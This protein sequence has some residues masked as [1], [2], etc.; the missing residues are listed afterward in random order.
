[1][2][3]FQQLIRQNRVRKGNKKNSMALKSFSRGKKKQKAMNNPQLRGSCI[4]TFVMTPKKPNSSSKKATKVKLSNGKEVTAYI[5]GEGHNLQAH[6]SVLVRGGRV[7]DLPGVFY[8][9]IRGKLDCDCV[10]NRKQGRSRFGAKM[11]KK[12]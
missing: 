8:K 2:P 9:V 4:S 10:K 6:S 12:K 7:R 11:E 3:T 5:P 1:M